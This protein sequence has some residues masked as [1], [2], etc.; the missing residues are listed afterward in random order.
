ME[1]LKVHI[2]PVILREFN[3][4]KNAAD[5]AKDISSVYSQ[6]VITDHKVQKWFSKYC[7]GNMLPRDEPRPGCSSNLN[8]NAIF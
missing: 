5:T 3:N 7:P 2:W 1:E 4:D 6:G 8:Q